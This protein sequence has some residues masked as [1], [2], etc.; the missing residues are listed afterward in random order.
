MPRMPYDII[1]AQP[2]SAFP[3]NLILRASD[4][5]L[6]GMAASSQ[7]AATTNGVFAVLLLL[8]LLL[9]IHLLPLLEL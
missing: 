7:L 5:T 1:L 8:L 3:Q 9:L 4:M 6:L 2:L